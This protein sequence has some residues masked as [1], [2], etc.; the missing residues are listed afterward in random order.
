MGGGV[1]IH[2]ANVSCGA[3]SKF[4]EGKSEALPPSSP[5]TMSTIPRQV[6][7]KIQS[8]FVH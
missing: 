2:T 1:H 8:D 5:V 4:L 3:K 6:L 7:G